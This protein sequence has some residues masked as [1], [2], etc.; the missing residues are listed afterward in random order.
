VPLADGQR[1]PVGRVAQ[2]LPAQRVQRRVVRVEHEAQPQRCPAGLGRR[3]GAP[4]RLAKRP[5]AEQHAAQR[6]AVRLQ[7]VAVGQQRLRIEP[8]APLLRQ[9][10]RDDAPRRRVLRHHDM[11]AIVLTAQAQLQVCRVHA[12]LW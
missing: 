3:A 12:M 4:Q 7:V 6:Q 5:L 1:R 9:G 2:R 8:Q 11:A 10:R